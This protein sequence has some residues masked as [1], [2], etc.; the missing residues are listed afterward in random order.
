MRHFER[1]N[2][3]TFTINIIMN[4]RLLLLIS[5][6]I[7]GALLA[8]TAYNFKIATDRMLFHDLVDKQQKAMLNEKDSLKLSPDDAINLQVA[9]VFLRQ[10]DELQ[11]KIESDTSLT[12]QVKVKSLKSLETLLKGYNRYR[13]KKDYPVSMAPA[14]FRAFMECLLLDRNGESI[15]PVIA[16]ND[17]GVGKLLIE[18]FLFPTENEGVKYSHVN[19]WKHIP[20]RYFPN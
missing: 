19:T 5:I 6:L 1:L 2:N 14:L 12:G 3:C 18:C 13:D 8:Q 20:I 15:E 10:V 17:Y 4:P 9:D 7:P 11:E 16:K